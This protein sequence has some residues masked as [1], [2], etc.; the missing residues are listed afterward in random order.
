MGAI[1]F[2]FATEITIPHQFVKKWKMEKKEPRRTTP[3]AIPDPA[4]PGEA[5]SNFSTDPV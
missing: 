5:G 1:F 3:E 2:L 4:Q